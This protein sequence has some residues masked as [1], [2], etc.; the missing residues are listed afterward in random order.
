MEAIHSRVVPLARDD[1]KHRDLQFFRI[2]AR[3]VATPL[4]A[5]VAQCVLGTVPVELVEGREVGKVDHV[6]LLELGGGAV[7]GRHHVDRHVGEVG[8]LGV[9]LA[10]AGGLEKDQV[11]VC[12]LQDPNRIGNGSGEG[13]VH[14]T[15]GQR[16]HEDPRT[17]DRVHADAVAEERAAGTASRGIDEQ[18]PDGAIGG[19]DAKAPDD[20]VQ[21]AG[22]P[23]AA[24]SR[25]AQH[26]GR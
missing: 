23:R 24:G 17:V 8:D 21:H 9:A 13:A 12:G 2:G 1:W 5:N 20:L 26:R 6:D 4:L 15:C 18:Q 7:F 22:L 11:E 10:D 16:A 3:V 14:L 19:V 25:K